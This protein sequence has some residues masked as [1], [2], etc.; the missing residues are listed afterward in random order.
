MSRKQ[1]DILPAVPVGFD[2]R[3]AVLELR[4]VMSLAQIAEYLGYASWSS[5]VQITNGAIPAHPQGE[6]LWVLYVRE[7]TRKPPI[8]EDQ[9]AGVFNSRQITATQPRRQ[10]Y[11]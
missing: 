11:K 10:G 6:A 3:Q 4:R 2:Y 7:F 8:T 1:P 9:A 5:I